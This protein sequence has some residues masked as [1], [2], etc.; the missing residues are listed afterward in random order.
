M[1]K[2][3][4]V[5]GIDVHKAMLAVVIGGA[6]MDESAYERRKYGTSTAQIRELA[7]W[8]HERGVVEVAMESTAQYWRTVWLGLEGKVRL[9]LAQARSNPAPKGRKSDYRDALRIVRRMLSNDLTLSFVAPAQQRIWRIWARTRVQ[10]IQ[11]QQQF[12]NQ[13][14]CILEE[15]Q[16]K[17]STV[18]SDLLGKTGRRIL[19]ALVKGESDPAGLAALADRR[20]RATSEQM[21]EACDGNMLPAHREIL[22]MFL[23]QIDGLEKQIQEIEKQLE[24]EQQEHVDA[25]QRLCEIP[26]INIQAARIIL[27]EVGAEAAAFATAEQLASWAGVCP[28]RDESAGIS[29]S[30][31]SPKG[32]RHLRRILNQVAWAAVR[33][34][35]CFFQIRFARWVVRLG[36]QKAAWAIA[37]KI[38]KLIWKV[39]KQ[40]VRYQEHGTLP[41][42]PKAVKRLRQRHTAALRKLGFT[43]TLTR[44]GQ[45]LE[46]SA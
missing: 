18:V 19:D 43:V 34:K 3:I 33:T 46:A 45:G 31:A 10:L 30:N 2:P 37:H 1:M 11:T 29:H 41:L 8:L 12:R 27:A 20:I 39:L 23:D 26:G 21:K 24:K 5:A 4:L 6:G 38:L 28:G 42:D 16:I 36:P 9:K 17:L 25:I 40:G 32:N 7:D 35:G 14:E 22:K 15:G 44:E 13:L